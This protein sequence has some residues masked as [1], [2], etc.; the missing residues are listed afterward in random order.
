MNEFIGIDA[1]RIALRIVAGLND[2][3]TDDDGGDQF[4]ALIEDVFGSD[5]PPPGEIMLALGRRLLVHYRGRYGAEAVG[6]V[7]ATELVALARR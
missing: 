7:L 4:G 2:A 1:D 3:V 5:A 6:S